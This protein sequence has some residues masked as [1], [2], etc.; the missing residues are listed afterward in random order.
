MVKNLISEKSKYMISNSFFIRNINKISKPI[1]LL[2]SKNNVK[3]N[4]ALLISGL[5][6]SNEIS[7]IL[8]VGANAG[9]TAQKF[10]KLG[11]RGRI[12]SF[13][14]IPSAFK[15]LK[16]RCSKFK[17]W[18]AI[19]AAIGSEIGE[20]DVFVAGNIESSSVLKMLDTHKKA[21]PNS[22]GTQVQKVKLQTL[23]SYYNS[24]IK[25][26]DQIFLKLD[27]QGYEPQV[28][29][30]AENILHLVKVLQIELSLI[31]LY[32]SAP[33]YKKV[34]QILEEKGF[35]LFSLWPGFADP[36]TGQLYQMDGIFIRK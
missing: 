19:E 25:P 22:V 31:P 34:I 4:E 11:F 18:T 24:S 30:G 28:L 5:L 1:G 17:N 7:L 36:I 15:E 12:L 27:V 6:K 3:N 33:D 23:N 13:E 26:T 32:D 14:P 2:I 8:D 10:L 21:A 9:Q 35:Q 16:K 20:V 29:Q